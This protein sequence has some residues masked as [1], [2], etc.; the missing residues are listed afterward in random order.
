MRYR[1]ESIIERPTV[2]STEPRRSELSA[3][4]EAVQT[5][6]TPEVTVADG[7]RALE[8][9]QAIEADALDEPT[10]TTPV[11]MEEE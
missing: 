11:P 1:H 8:L 10:P 2:P 5:G 9:A 4:L 7:V 6:T 3:F